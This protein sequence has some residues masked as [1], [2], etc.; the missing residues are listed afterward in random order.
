MYSWRYTI[1]DFFP[2]AETSHKGV[3]PS[4]DEFQLPLTSFPVNLAKMPETMEISDAAKSGDN[5]VENVGIQC[6]VQA[7]N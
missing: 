4:L 6:N 1:F 5:T 3:V 2:R 7:C